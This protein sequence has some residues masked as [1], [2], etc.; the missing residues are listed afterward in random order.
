VTNKFG[1]CVARF[2]VLHF[3]SEKPEQENV[4]Q[5]DMD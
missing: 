3:L 5:E 4:G 1:A 2:P